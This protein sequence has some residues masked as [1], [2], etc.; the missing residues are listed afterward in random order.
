MVGMINNEDNREVG[1]N[2]FSDSVK[3]YYKELKYYKPIS[4]E[5]E[6]RL[7]KLAKEGDVDARNRIVNANLRFVFN[8]SKKYRNNGV[9]IADLISAG[10]NG[11][12]KAI[13]RFDMSRD[14]KFF[15]YAVWWIRQH[16][17]KE[18]VS[19][20]ER[21]TNESGFDDVFRDNAHPDNVCPDDD[22][23]ENDA[24]L[25]GISDNNVDFYEVQQKHFVVEKL[26]AKLD[27]RERI[28]ISKYFGIEDDSD[29]HNINEIGKELNLSS[30]RV[31]QLK[32]KA[33]NT[34]RAEVFDMK[35]ADFLF[36]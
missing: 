36:R 24:S 8:I 23:E 12:F 22:I 14:V 17:M 19:Q 5:E 6:R 16:M 31:R 21:E 15:S 1:K 28:I 4:K 25:N 11:M 32:I 26:L 3:I 13:E 35:E 20:R 30:E 18:I 10:N 9:D 7:L 27:D 33:I 29:G 34:M 2:D